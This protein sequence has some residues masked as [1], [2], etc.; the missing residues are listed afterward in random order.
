MAELSPT[1]LRTRLAPVLFSLAVL[2]VGGF[3]LWFYVMSLRSVESVLERQT[4]AAVQ[5]AATGIEAAYEDLLAI[6]SL[7]ARSRVVRDALGA[8]SPPRDE[9]RAYAQWFLEKAGGRFDQIIFLDADGDPV[10]KLDPG[11]S[12]A[13]DPALE[14]GAVVAPT[15]EPSDRGGLPAPGQGLRVS[16]QS[17]IAR[18]QVFRFSRPVGGS[19]LRRSTA[20]A[21]APSGYVSLD[22]RVDRLLTLQAGGDEALIIIERGASSVLLAPDPRLHGQ[23]LAMALPEL[24]SAL[25]ATDNEASRSLRFD[26]EGAEYVASCMRLDDPAW[27]LVAWIDA[28][29]YIAGPRST[30]QFTLA[31]AALFALLTGALILVLV[32]RVQRRTVLLQ[33]ANEQLEAQNRRVQE[34]NARIAQETENKSQFLRRMAHD[35]RSPMNAIIGYTRLVLRKARGVLDERQVGNLENIETSSHNLLNLINEILDLSRIEAG[36][37]EIKRQAVDVRQLAG[38]CADALG[39]LVRPGVDLHRELADV[40]QLHTD[41]DRL[42]QVIMNLLGNATKF[43]DTGSITLSLRRDGAAIELSVADTGIG[44]PANDLPHIF[45][46]FRQVERQGGEPSEGTGL[47]LAIARKTVRLLGGEIRATSA[48]GVGTTFTVRLAS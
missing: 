11:N 41:P 31:V 7:S 17:T 20:G 13:L 47:G 19:R 25:A 37:V 26:R 43:T 2:P 3:A 42:R 44:I 29:P 45:D 40:G 12:A 38:E 15:F 9:L 18:G 24:A 36:R 30:G 1:R 32:N 23:P 10:D 16:V 6:G 46:E 33:E 39:S 28:G 4:L 8:A 21:A 5:N 48:V 27:T 35:L 14:S 22:V 34:A